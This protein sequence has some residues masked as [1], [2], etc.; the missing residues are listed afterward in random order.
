MSN[1]PE[2]EI[3]QN[4]TPEEARQSLLAELGQ[5]AGDCELGNEQVERS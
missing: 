1:Q 4:M 2:N 5:S 3:Q